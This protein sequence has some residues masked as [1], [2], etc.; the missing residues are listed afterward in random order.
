MLDHNPFTGADWR[1][2]GEEAA[3]AAGT[4]AEGPPLRIA[5]PVPLRAGT[6]PDLNYGVRSNAQLLL[7]CV[8]GLTA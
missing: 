5:S 1:P 6:V 8:L 7:T 3:P 4:A 2:S